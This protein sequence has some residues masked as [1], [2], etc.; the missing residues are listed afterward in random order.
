MFTKLAA[1]L[2]EAELTSRSTE[3]ALIEKAEWLAR[4]MTRLAEKVADDPSCFAVNSIG[5]VQGTGPAIDALCGTL[6]AARKNE[7]MI[8]ELRDIEIRDSEP[9]TAFA[10]VIDHLVDGDTVAHEQVLEILE[11]WTADQVAGAAAAVELKSAVEF[12]DDPAAAGA[13]AGLAE[14]LTYI[15][16]ERR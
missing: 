9:L 13:I 3:R 14:E 10:G 6:A 5:E 11:G 4:D 15:A 16:D 1:L 2:H 7:F 8:R 12:K